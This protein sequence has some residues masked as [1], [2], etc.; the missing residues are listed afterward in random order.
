MTVSWVD[1]SKT[2]EIDEGTE[3]NHA[4]HCVTNVETG[5]HVEMVFLSSIMF[6]NFKAI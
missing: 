1:E 3:L 4:F 5:H 2:I 6:I